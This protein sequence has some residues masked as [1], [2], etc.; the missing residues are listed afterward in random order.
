MMRLVLP[1]RLGSRASLCVLAHLF[2][3]TVDPREE[4]GVLTDGRQH[5]PQRPTVEGCSMPILV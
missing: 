2:L 3:P 5:V 4:V 1:R